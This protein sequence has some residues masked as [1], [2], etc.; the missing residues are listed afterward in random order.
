MK[1][2]LFLLMLLCFAILSSPAIGQ[3]LSLNYDQIQTVDGEI[4]VPLRQVAQFA[5]F[6]VHY[7]QGEVTLT[8]EGKQVKLNLKDGTL[9]DNGHRVYLWPELCVIEKIMYVPMSLL[10]DHLR[11]D[12]KLNRSSLTVSKVLENKITISN[13]RETFEEQYLDLQLQYP[14]IGGL[15]NEAQKLINDTIKGKM[16]AIKEDAHKDKE[17]FIANPHWSASHQVS[18]DTNY[19]VKRNRGGLLSVLFEDYRFLGGAHGNADKFAYNFDLKTGKQYSL[20]D[21]FAKDVDYVSIIN[22]EIAALIAGD[23]YKSQYY[24][25]DS[26]APDQVF[27][28]GNNALVICFQSY[29]IAAYAEGK[30]EFAIPFSQLEK[31]LNPMLA[32]ALK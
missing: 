2:K 10:E 30:P 4:L 19:L 17:E 16:A 29:E 18:Y 27:Y 13:Q 25:F 7:T 3:S 23:K 31:V 1:K 26:I 32:E 20:K 24:S 15:E 12:P 9:A 21:L 6:T 28:L 5:G 8:K 22:K 11:V 14:R